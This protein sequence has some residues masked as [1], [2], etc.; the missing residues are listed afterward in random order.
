MV[1]LNLLVTIWCLVVLKIYTPIKN[2]LSANRQYAKL[3][4]SP[5]PGGVLFGTLVVWLFGWI[6]LENDQMTI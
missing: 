4:E 3:E 1:C 5:P 6:Y 2:R